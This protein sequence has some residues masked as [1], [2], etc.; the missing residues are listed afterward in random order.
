MTNLRQA[1]LYGAT[2]SEANL[3]LVRMEGALL[4]GA[5]LKNAQ[6][7]N[8][9]WAGARIRFAD[10]RKVT[11]RFDLDEIKKCKDWQLAF[12]D[13]DVLQQ[14][15]LPPD[16]NDALDQYRKSEPRETFDSWVLKWRQEKKQ[17]PP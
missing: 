3:E 14:L 16:N 5:S 17:T 7:L 10:L 12:Y 2:L 13:G 9:R 15:G 1:D 11:P 4:E 6:V 8:V